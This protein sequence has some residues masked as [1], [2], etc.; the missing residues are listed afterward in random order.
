MA[1]KDRVPLPGFS[2]PTQA[3]HGFT[4]FTTFHEFVIVCAISCKKTRL[5]FELSPCLSRACLGKVIVLSLK[6][7]TKTRLLTVRGL[8]P[9]LTMAD[10]MDTPSMP[11]RNRVAHFLTFRKCACVPSP[12]WQMIN[13]K[14]ERRKSRRHKKGSFPRAPLSVM[15]S[16]A[17]ASTSQSIPSMQFAVRCW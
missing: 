3:L 9:P 4:P 10:H 17:V 14:F 16:F 15:C 1:Q 13:F 12:S 6:W 5:C 11:A 8:G 2:L 7:R